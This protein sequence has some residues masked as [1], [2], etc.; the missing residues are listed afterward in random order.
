MKSAFGSHARTRGIEGPRNGAPLLSL[1]PSPLRVFEFFDLEQNGSV[2]LLGY[3]DWQHAKVLV[4]RG[5]R[6]RKY[7]DSVWPLRKIHLAFLSIFISN[8]IR[9]I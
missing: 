8:G 6:A 4:L 2:I 3:N 5:P 7:P 9:A 1:F